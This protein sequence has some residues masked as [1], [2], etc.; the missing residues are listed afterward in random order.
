MNIL[1]NFRDFFF[2]VFLGID[3]SVTS[4]EVGSFLMVLQQHLQTFK[5]SPG[6]VS[7]SRASP[8]A[9]SWRQSCP[10]GLS[11][12]RHWTTSVNISGTK[13]KQVDHLIS[14]HFQMIGISPNQGLSSTFPC[15]KDRNLEIYT[16]TSLLWFTNPI[17]IVPIGQY[18]PL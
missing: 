5:W 12:Q 1:G 8:M 3:Y 9:L 2:S 18:F 10:V 15:Y 16:S 17:Q 13:R 7:S 14:H 11:C 4:C 6:K